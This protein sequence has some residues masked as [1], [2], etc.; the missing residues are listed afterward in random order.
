MIKFASKYF[1]I[2]NCKTNG[3]KCTPG[4]LGLGIQLKKK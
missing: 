2:A 4:S 3:V 1:N